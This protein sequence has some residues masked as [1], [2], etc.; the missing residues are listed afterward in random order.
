MGENK[1][2]QKERKRGNVYRNAVQLI[3]VGAV[4]GIFA[5]AVVTVYNLFASEGER[6]S[7]DVYAYIRQNP[8]FVPL[9]FNRSRPGALFSERRRPARSHD[10]G[11]RHSADGGRDARR[12]SFPLVQGSGGDVCGQAC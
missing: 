6:I 11:K 3:A 8:V 2:I 10:Q 7:R 12:Y 5:G 1:R 9:L 4:T